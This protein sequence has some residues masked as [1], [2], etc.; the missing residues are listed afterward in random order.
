MWKLKALEEV[1]CDCENFDGSF[2]ALVQSVYICRKL[3]MFLAVSKSGQVF[4]KL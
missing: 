2:A 1:L 4:T 3:I